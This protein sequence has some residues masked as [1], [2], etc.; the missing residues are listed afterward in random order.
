VH[1]GVGLLIPLLLLI[2][3][4]RSQASLATAGGLIALA[5]ISTKLNLVIPALVVPEF[6][7]LRTAFTGLGLTFDYFPT[8]TEWLLTVWV[9]SLAALIFPAG[10]RFLPAR[11]SEQTT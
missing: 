10:Y 6:E 8:L 9:M 2:F 1:V 5:A 3:A 7:G 4:G 11:V